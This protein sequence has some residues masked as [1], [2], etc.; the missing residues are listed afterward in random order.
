[1]KEVKVKLYKF[2]ELSKEVKEKLI[3][4]EA[5]YEAEFYM[6]NFLYDDL[7]EEAKMKLNSI[8][9]NVKINSILYDFS[10]SQ[11]SGLLIEFEADWLNGFHFE[12]KQNPNN[13]HYT[14]CKNFVVDFEGYFSTKD[15]IDI[16]QIIESANEEIY[17]YGDSQINAEE[18]FKKIAEEKLEEDEEESYLE[19][20]DIF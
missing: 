13:W 15:K 4:K 18:Y 20:G 16:K 19:N 8:F 3:E 12:V 5:K 1:M 14:Y 7:K 2:N 11:G 9:K 6:E 10:Y 17:E